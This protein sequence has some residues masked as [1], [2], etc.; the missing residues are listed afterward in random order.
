M[1]VFNKYAIYVFLD[2]IILCL[3]CKQYFNSSGVNFKVVVANQPKNQP[4]KRNNIY[5]LEN[6]S[7]TIQRV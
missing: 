2:T 4:S 5:S 3:H 7:F 1:Y 6:S